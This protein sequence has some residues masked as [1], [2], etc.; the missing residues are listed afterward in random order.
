MSTREWKFRIDDII[1]AIEKI[2]NY[3][4]GVD[5]KRFHSESLLE[6][7]VIRNLEIIGEASNHIPEDVRLR[8]PEIPWH[9]MKGIRNILIHE[10][11]G[12][13]SETVWNTVQSDLPRLKIQLLK[14]IN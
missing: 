6:D 10:Y 8:Y 1:K 13:D 5:L 14:I 4:K 12:V 2:E 11:F 7:A 9:Q 3:L